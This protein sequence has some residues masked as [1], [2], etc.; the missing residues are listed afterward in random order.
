[1]KFRVSHISNSLKEDV[2]VLST[3]TGQKNKLLLWLMWFL[4][5]AVV[6]FGAILPGISGGTLCVAFGM[7]QPLMETF[8]SLKTG[9]KKHGFMLGI[10]LLGVAAGFV[11]LSGLAATLLE[12]NVMVATCVFVGFIL[13]TFPELWRDAGNSGR[14]GNSYV[15]L[16]VCFAVMMLVLF[17]LKTKLS[18]MI[19][20]S[21]FAYIFCGIL[22]GLGIVVP[23]LGSSSLLLFFGLYQPMLE[24]I[25]NLNMLVIIPMAI[26]ILFCMVLFPKAV[27]AAYRKSYSAVSHGVIGIVA[28][29][30]VMIL[31]YRVESASQWIIN[32]LCIL[33]GA[34]VSYLLSSICDKLKSQAE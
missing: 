18:L 6:G 32:I 31:P 11:G 17:S 27:A 10:F 34:V 7:Y 29:T 33:G 30:V 28:A 25:A 21:F 4:E 2:K 5:G 13:G 16:I 22:W 26:G 23:G 20:P 12:R 19:A 24:G 1:M 15:S 8:S 3:G 14:N 9:I